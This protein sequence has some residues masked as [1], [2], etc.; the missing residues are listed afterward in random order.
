MV[1]RTPRRAADRARKRQARLKAPAARREPLAAATRHEKRRLKGAGKS[2]ER[3]GK[4][5]RKS[6]RAKPC[7]GSLAAE[8]VFTYG[9]AEA[10][11]AAAARRDGLSV[12]RPSLPPSER[13]GPGTGRAYQRLRSVDRAFRSLKTGILKGRPVSPRPPGPRPRLPVPARLLRRMAPAPETDAPAVR[14][15]GGGRRRGP[16]AGR[17]GADARL[18]QRPGQGRQQA[19]R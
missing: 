2:G 17:R 6:K 9:R 18:G 10:A 7:T 8:G 3:G 14:R 5:S 19:E 4:G 1:G 16:A 12:I 13:A 11:S 15:R